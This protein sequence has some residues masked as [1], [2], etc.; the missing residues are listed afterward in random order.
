MSLLIARTAVDKT[1]Y[2]FDKLFDYIVPEYLYRKIAVGKRVLVPFGSGSR[3]RQA[4]VME[5][6]RQEEPNQKLKEVSAVLDDNSI[7][8]EEMLKL[9]L[10]M[11]ERCFCTYYDAVR[12]MLPTGINYRISSIYALAVDAI[13]EN[14]T[15]EQKKVLEL[16][17]TSAK[18][19]KQETLFKKLDIDCE[20]KAITQLLELNILKKTENVMRKVNDSSVKMLRLCDF[21]T[22]SVKLTERQKEVY[23]LLTSAGEVSVREVCYYTGV[24]RSV[25]ET[26]VKKGIC[27]CFEQEQFRIPVSSYASE[28][29]PVILTQEQEQAHNDLLNLYKSNKAAVSL[30]YGVTGAGK[31]SVFLKL[32]ETVYRQGKGVIVM[33]PE[34]ALT[35]QVVSLFK[36]RFGQ[37]VAVFHS[38]LSMGERLDEWKRVR[39]GIAKIAVGTRSAVFAP[40]EKIGLIIIDEE[41]E[42]TYKSESS[43]RFHARDI[44]KLRCFEHNALLVL[45]SA[46]PSIES[47][48]YS[49]TGRYSMSKLTKRYG[50]AQLPD[51]TVIDMNEEKTTGSLTGFSETLLNAVAENL[52][53]GEQSILLLNRRGY[54]TFVSCKNCREV[55]TCPNCSISLTYHSANNRLMCHYCGFSMRITDKC[56]ECGSRELKYSGSGTQKAEQSLSAFF[57]EARILRLDA[58]STLAKQS[59]EKKLTEFKNGEYDI[60]I[61]TQ[62]VAKGLNFPKVTLVGVLSAD[63]TLY[64]EDFRSYERAF[65]LLT[66]VVGRSGRGER[67][68]Q[69]LIQTYTPENP[70]MSLAAAQNYDEF[71]NSEIKIRKTM[72]YPPFCEICMIGFVS[73]KEV[74][75]AEAAALFTQE[76]CKIMKENYSDLPVRIL[77]PSPA[78]VYRVNNKYRY[79]LILKIKNTVKFR[80]MLSEVLIDFTKSRKYNDVT[81]YADINPDNIL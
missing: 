49:Q 55:V 32:M 9:V 5:L 29:Q 68:G 28:Q 46:T 20:S 31:T 63:Q 3:K 8:T 48:Y 69:A 27:E 7:L 76:L 22:E 43:P 78:A 33:V 41:Q 75:C 60:L 36:A 24:T 44:A 57:P 52:E 10:S 66:Q 16:F 6:I 54:N 35:P 73:Q 19:V 72:L 26:L 13:P 18:S 61:G 34:I 2:H 81:V 67:H 80:Q 25:I 14:L 58:D 30:L 53:K 23:G 38:A 45:S 37:D 40:F 47:C 15:D 56:P 17:K 1:L 39:C 4:M 21:D 77:G 12:A 70:I 64:S 71:Y 65:S 11:K 50:N 51:V 62:M 42:Y 79:K 74:R 59:H